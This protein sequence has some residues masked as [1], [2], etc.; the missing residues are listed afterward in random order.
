[1][2][3][4][5][6]SITR[7]ESSR[8]RARYTETNIQCFNRYSRANSTQVRLGILS[9]DWLEPNENVDVLSL[10]LLLESVSRSRFRENLETARS[11]L[12]PASAGMCGMEIIES[13]GAAGP[14][15]HDR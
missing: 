9:F 1:M 6:C 11:P 2:P 4:F 10:R 3:S 12:H 15:R 14:A 8:E 13:R 5:L 7:T